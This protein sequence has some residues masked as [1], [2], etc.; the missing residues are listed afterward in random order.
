M[1]LQVFQHVLAEM[2]MSPGFRVAVQDN[3]EQALVT[4][5]LTSQE[6]QRL[7]TIAHDPGVK[8]GTMIHRSFRIGMFANRLPR[9]CTA[10][11]TQE[12]QRMLLEYWETHPP[13]TLFYAQEAARFASFVSAQIAQGKL[14]NPYVEA[15]LKLELGLI[16]L[17]S[18]SG[19]PEQGA[20]DIEHIS[21]DMS[22]ATHPAC[23]VIQFDHDPNILL[24]SLNAGEIPETVPR[25][26]YYILLK[27]S[28]DGQ[29]H[30]H[31]ISSTLGVVLL[32]CNEPRTLA[33]LQDY[34]V[35][36][37]DNAAT[38]IH[39]GYLCV[40]QHTTEYMTS[41]VEEQLVV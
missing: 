37:T 27:R 25:G 2:V 8:I 18:S 9:T 30:T 26:E 16:E 29:M 12:L 13:Q 31:Q 10:L 7:A 17:A 41:S 3:A 34:N 23:R 4:F 6:R 20:P 38:L 24:P 35:L 11:G 36:T 1:S 21:L 32:I 33:W 22:V 15:V 39:S 40:W 5:Q 28:T 19:I 14:Y